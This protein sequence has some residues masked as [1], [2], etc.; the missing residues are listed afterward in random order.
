MSIPLQVIIIEDSE[1]DALLLVQILRR[2]GYDPFCERVDNGPALSAALARRSWDIVIAD[3]SMP[4]FNS[5]AAL[6]IIKEGGLDIPF[7]IVSAHISEDEAAEVMHLG[8]KD[9]VMKENLTRL[10]PAIDRELR[11]AQDRRD[12]RRAEA[13]VQHQAY[14]DPLTDL[15]NRLMF[16]DRLTMAVAQA[17]HNRKM[18][19][20]LFVDLDRFKT[21]VD[22]LG[23][24]VGDRVLRGVAGRLQ[25]CLE[26]NDTLARL[27]GDEFVVLLPEI[28]RADQA[29]KLAQKILDVLKPSFLFS[30]QELHITTSIGI[31][32]Y[33]YDGEDADTLLKN[34]DTA[35][36]RAKEQGR[37][38]YQLYTPAMNSRAFERLALENSLRKA[39]E[40]SEF[41]LHYQPQVNMQT[42]AIVGMEALLRW[43]H[44]DL[45]LV[46]PAEFIPLAEE[47]GLIVPMGECVIRMAC[48]QAKAWQVDGLPPLTVAVNLSARQF[49]HHDLVETVARILKETELDPRWLEVEITESVA[50]QNVDYTMVI[51]KELKEMGILIAVDDFGTGHSSLSYLKKFPINT[52][53]IDQSFIRDL[54]Q[55]DNDAAIANAVIVLAHSMKLRV[56]AEGVETPEQETFLRE[57]HCDQF[58][59]YLFAHPVPAAVFE[60]LLRQH[61]QKTA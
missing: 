53:K 30:G 6:K 38:N 57:H 8:A 35:L 39:I 12:R 2:G 58:Q 17:S 7:I 15:P 10:C 32:L 46:Y 49:Q 56:I 37:D 59:G 51:L 43:Q 16:T 29:V 41:L 54:N 40:R 52:L 5:I 31:A 18:L 60:S 42:N 9:Y 27:G 26:E 22:T 44:P 14:Y 1:A 50:M 48:A 33:P 20:V 13:T 34:A 47:T 21:I 28:L 55:G 36:Y 19:A 45:G 4:Q 3:H 23:H 61:L 24:T 25:N 11:E